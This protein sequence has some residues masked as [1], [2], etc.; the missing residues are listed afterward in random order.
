MNWSFYCL[1]WKSESCFY[2]FDDIHFC[3]HHVTFLDTVKDSFLFGDVMQYFVNDRQNQRNKITNSKICRPWNQSRNVFDGMICFYPDLNRGLNLC[4]LLLKTVW[5]SKV[6]HECIN[7]HY[8]T[9]YS[10]PKD[11]WSSLLEIFR[12]EPSTSSFGK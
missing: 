3:S 5:M 10:I 4:I 12:T 2:E 6:S 7:Y 11:M 8:I 9:F 1:S